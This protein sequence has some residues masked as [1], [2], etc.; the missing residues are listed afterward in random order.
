MSLASPQDAPSPAEELTL[1]LV[2]EERTPRTWPKSV[3]EVARWCRAAKADAV[4]E[5]EV[6]GANES[7]RGQ[8]AA[9]GGVAAALA[10]RS[11]SS[12]LFSS[13]PA[14]IQ[15]W[16]ELAPEPPQNLVDELYRDLKREFD[17]LAL[18][19]E[20]IVAGP[21]RR[22]LGTFF[23]PTPVLTYVERLVKGLRDK[24]ATVADP[25]AGV[26]AFTVAALRWWNTAK[27]HAVDVNLVTLGLLATR[28]DLLRRRTGGDLSARLRI[29]H[30]D[31]L[32][33]LTSAWPELPGPRLILGN[34]PYT[35]HQQ[36]TLSEKTAAR[37]AAGTLAP[38][39]RSGLSTYFLAAALHSLGQ[40]DS[41]CLLLPANWL[42]ADYARSVRRHLWT[43][44][45]RRVEL[46]VFPNDL[47]VFPGTQVSA[48]IL[49]VGPERRYKQPMKL[50]DVDGDLDRGFSKYISATLKRDGPPPLSFTPDKLIARPPMVQVVASE[51]AVPIG[52]IAIVRRG[53]ATGANSFF[54]LTKDDAMALPDGSCV[55]AI[56]RLRDF[57][58]TLLDK[59]AHDK[60][61]SNGA[62]CWLLYLDA[63]GYTAP[64]IKKMIDVGVHSKI[65]QRY[66]CRTRDPWYAV[67]K[68]PAPDILIGPMG[69]ESFR[70]VINKV[71]A[72]PTN[73][74]YGLRFRH[75]SI[76]YLSQMVQALA[77][78]LSSAV[79][80]EALRAAARK[81]HG[82]GLVKLEPGAVALVRV[83]A[84]LA[85]GL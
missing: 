51:K 40:N 65:D 33:W 62:R 4:P 84:D 44:N 12:A 67:E 70:I 68:I 36:M 85:V 18:V 43:S 30:K 42:E 69:K 35:R 45:R 53:V 21:R 46:H 1:D 14:A 8:L 50:I 6:P 34:P 9:L 32:G 28:P 25:G 83:P 80:Q 58:G 10:R 60:L 39:A 19:Y 76:R 27:V 23:T 72:I 16:L 66:L 26:G 82:D 64:G 3:S 78:W 59:K 24:P 48:M 71:G 11:K 41:L 56:S 74:L 2:S 31:F 55:P 37:A 79:G 54:V 49:L 7:E 77:N 81:H 47:S 38:G 73:T 75:R 61:G 52:Q 57:H 17:P 13:F 29:G 63:G 22:Q 15:E 5:A 20:R